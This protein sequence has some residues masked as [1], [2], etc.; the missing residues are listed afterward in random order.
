LGGAQAPKFT[1]GI[2]SEA[3]ETSGRGA[4]C[5]EREDSRQPILLIPRSQDEDAVDYGQSPDLTVS[6][7]A[8]WPFP[9]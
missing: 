1:Y 2:L 3:E 5:E 4:R 9:A 7:R 8:Q 6:S